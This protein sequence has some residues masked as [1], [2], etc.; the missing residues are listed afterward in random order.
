MPIK[1][2][3][4][5]ANGHCV[6]DKNT[7]DILFSDPVTAEDA[8]A[9]RLPKGLLGPMVVS[10]IPVTCGHCDVYWKMGFTEDTARI[11]EPCAYPN[12]ITTVI[13]LAVPSGKIIVT[14]DLRDV[15]D[16][17]DHDGF[18]SYNTS[19]GQA[20][21]IEAMAALGCAYGPVGNSCPSLYR[22]LDGTYVIGNPEYDDDDEPTGDLATAETLA[23]ICTDLW[24]YSIADYEDWKSRGGDE[25][26]LRNKGAIVEVPPG[27][28]QFTHHTGE[29]GFEHYAAGEVIFAHIERIS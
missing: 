3:K 6:S 26:I 18:A 28:Y 24:A 21:V 14:D 16:G 29:N 23:D 25:E 11:T 15:Y 4:F 27:V 9:W 20:Q 19:R 8:K 10:Q 2:L 12:G 1:T 5:D 13:T 17:F 22:L 7:V